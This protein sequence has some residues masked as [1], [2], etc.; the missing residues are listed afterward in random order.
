VNHPP[1]QLPPPVV[2]RTTIWFA[3]GNDTPAPITLNT[4][5][6]LGI[7]TGQPLPHGGVNPTITVDLRTLL[8]K[9]KKGLA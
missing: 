5:R 2:P 9:V 6:I 1:N 4:G 7:P 3:Q 8:N